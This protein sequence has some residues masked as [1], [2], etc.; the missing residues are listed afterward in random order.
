LKGKENIYLIYY[1]IYYG[2]GDS[3][4]VSPNFPS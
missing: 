4:I 3:P 2:N 1:V